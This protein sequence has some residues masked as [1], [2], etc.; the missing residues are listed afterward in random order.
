MGSTLRKHRY[1]VPVT[2]RSTDVSQMEQ[3]S[4]RFFLALFNEKEQANASFFGLGSA[5]H[6]SIERGILEDMKLPDMITDVENR[7]VAF[8]GEA[9]ANERR[10]IETSKRG[11][12]TMLEDADRMI[13]NWFNHVHPA[14]NDRH[15]I[16]DDYEWPPMVEHRFERTANSAG[17]QYPVWGSVDALFE[18]KIPHDEESHYM[19]VDWK[20]GTQKQRSDF[21]LHFYRFGLGMGDV[22]AHYHHLDRVRK[23]AIVQVGDAYP[24]DPEMA[25]LITETEQIKLAV[26]DGGKPEFIPSFLCNFCP[27]QDFCL[28]DGDPRNHHANRRS[29]KKM[30]HLAVPLKIVLRK[31]ESDGI[32]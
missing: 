21:Q 28:A 8:L 6:E 30:L 23:N 2:T 4:G 5:L 1:Q 10:I 7:V 29:F 27:V 15:P 31:E 19:I 25:R 14:G 16:Y 13:V 11:M 12:D 22:P 17:T 20:S 26:L 24:G 32:Q 9:K 18:H 3:C